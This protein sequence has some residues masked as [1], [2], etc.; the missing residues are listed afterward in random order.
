MPTQYFPGIVQAVL[1]YTATSHYGGTT[2]VH[3][4]LVTSSSSWSAT[5]NLYGKTGWEAHSTWS[6]VLGKTT[7]CAMQMNQWYLDGTEPRTQIKVVWE[8]EM[9][10]CFGL[11]HVT[12]VHHVMYNSASVAYADGVAGLTTDEINGIKALY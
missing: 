5:A 2:P 9:G 8:H 10:H 11:D 7:S 1:D 12:A 3:L 4:T 6:C